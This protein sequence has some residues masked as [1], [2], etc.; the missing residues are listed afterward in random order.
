MN[1][2]LVVFF[3]LLAVLGISFLVIRYKAKKFLK[4][5]FNSDDLQTIIASQREIEAN[6]VQSVSGMTSI[7]LPLIANDFPA[8]HYDEFKHRAT[9]MLI[10]ALQAISD[11]Q[12]NRL[13][14]ASSELI[15]KVNLMIKGNQMSHV[16]EKYSSIQ[17]H[18]MEIFSYR[19]QEGTCTIVL[20]CALSYFYEKKEANQIVVESHY[21]TQTKYNI[22][23]LFVQDET[24]LEDQKQTTY[25]VANC[26]N[27]GAKIKNKNNK[28][29]AYCGSQVELVNIHVWQIHD[30]SRIK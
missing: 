13:Q 23:L 4:Q 10:S 25:N 12:I 8:F 26:P 19:K 1:V 9:Q 24:L 29:C 6:S 20:Q 7:Y 17:M 11:E 21:R 28:V 27:C 22:E 14:Y 18:Q 15:T 16:Q 3:T 5:H 2:F 30:F